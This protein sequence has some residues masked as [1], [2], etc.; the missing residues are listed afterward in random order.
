MGSLSGSADVEAGEA[1]LWDAVS[2]HGIGA[3]TD[4][5]CSELGARKQRC[6]GR[7][8]IGRAHV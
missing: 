7:Q 8:E 5:L 6:G 1:R 4:G 3:L 2:M